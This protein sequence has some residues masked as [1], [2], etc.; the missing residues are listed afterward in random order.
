[1]PPGRGL[2]AYREVWLV[3]TEFSQPPGERPIPVCLVAREFRTGRTFR[4]WEDD[5]R[6][7]RM[8]PYSI[9]PD[10]LF[11]AY[12]A[13]AELGCHLVL[14][15]PLPSRILDLYVEFRAKLNGFTPPNGFGLLGA[16]TYHGLDAMS[17]AAKKAMQQLADRGGPWT[18]AERQALL[19]YCES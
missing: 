15:W 9:G 7:R 17:V 14:D 16:L 4:L 19:D 6:A 10:S 18:S 3:D 8:P 2:S 5:L 1:M 12:L 11:V 13:S